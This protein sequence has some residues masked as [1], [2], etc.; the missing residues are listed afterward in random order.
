MEKGEMQGRKGEVRK[1][2]KERD[3]KGEKRKAEERK[4]LLQRKGKVLRERKGK[5]KELGQIR[6]G[7]QKGGQAGGGG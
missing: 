1:G 3:G 5:E 2:R 6:K 4:G 7:R